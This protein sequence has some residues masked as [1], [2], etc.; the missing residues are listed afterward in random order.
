M[1]QI[2]KIKGLEHIS[3][4]YYITTCGKVISMFDGTPKIRITKI[5]NSGYKS[6]NLVN[7]YNKYTHINVHRLVVLAFIPN[8]ENKS[9]VNHKNEI[10]TDNYV[11]NLE[12]VTHK[13]NSN[14]GTR[15]ER[16]SQKQKMVDKT[17]ATGSN[18]YSAKPK[19]YYATTPY[20]RSA[21]KN[22]ICKHQGW[23][24]NDFEEVFAE[25]HWY[26]GRR[27][28]KYYYIYKGVTNEQR[29]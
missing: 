11:G 26:S 27:K 7:K 19:E 9:Q 2:S 29:P 4:Y 10:K 17:Y 8:L 14:Y 20:Y 5:K 6:V 25:W 18:N 23:D 13:E 21:F 28:R 15:N 22:I 3:D 16:I 1:L 24:F 12:W